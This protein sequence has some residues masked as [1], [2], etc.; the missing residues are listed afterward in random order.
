MAK[1]QDLYKWDLYVQDKRKGHNSN[2][3]FLKKKQCI[4]LAFRRTFPYFDTV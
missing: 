1:L 2:D 3:L 4:K